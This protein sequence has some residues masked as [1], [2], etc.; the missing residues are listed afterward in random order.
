MSPNCRRVKDGRAFSRRHAHKIRAVKSDKRT[1][2][3]V[4]SLHEYVAGR[5]AAG[6]DQAKVS[7][8]A[9]ERR[10]DSA[11]SMLLSE[12]PQRAA[13]AATSKPDPACPLPIEG[14]RAAPAQE[15]DYPPRPEG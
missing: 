13:R 6:E 5:P 14:R 11:G 9:D 2:V 3:V 4:E 12:D 15:N 10:S 8:P 1:L 7:I